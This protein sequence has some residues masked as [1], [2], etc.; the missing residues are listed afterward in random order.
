TSAAEDLEALAVAIVRGGFEYQGQKCSAC[1]RVYV[2]ESVWTKLK[3]RLTEMV[4]EHRM[5]D[6]ADFRNFMGAVIDEG[7]F[8]NVSSDIELAKNGP[9]ATILVGGE[10]DRREGYFVRP[11]LVQLQNPRHRIM[12]EEIFAPV[13]GIY[14]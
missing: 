5:G 9:D 11:T 14:V 7:S 6:I 4:A 1:S 3:P 12:T 8:K 13:V 2:P 10:T